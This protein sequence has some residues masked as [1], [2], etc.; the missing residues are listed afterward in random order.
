MTGWYPDHHKLL[1]PSADESSPSLQLPDNMPLL[2]LIMKSYDYSTAGFVSS[3]SVGFLADY[4]DKFIEFDEQN[5]PSRLTGFRKTTNA[6]LDWLEKNKD[7]KFFLFIHFWDPHS[8]YEPISKHD[9]FKSTQLDQLS[10]KAAKYAGEIQYMDSKIGELLN[11]IK[12]LELEKDTLILFTSDHGE[13]FGE[14]P[15]DDFTWN[16]GPCED[17]SVSVLD[18][19]I[20]IPLIIKIPGM[21]AKKIESISQSVDLLPTILD[22]VG[23]P[24]TQP[25]D[26]SSLLDLIG[27]DENENRF[28]Y[29]IIPKNLV[30]SN[31]YT[32][33]LRWKEWK[34]IRVTWIDDKTHQ[35]KFILRLHN[36]TLGEKENFL[37]KEP[38][39]VKKLLQQ[40]EV[41][42][43][44]TPLQGLREENLD[45]ET[46]KMLKSL[47]Y[48]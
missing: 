10:I 24:Q 17:H 25:T 4:F 31:I 20:K 6:S 18:P 34:L 22:L 8:P 41:L 5:D 40:I 32:S 12:K 48:L 7:E 33:G 15:C 38:D 36:T 43:A 35:N 1:I 21:N 42:E 23:I 30:E 11:E 9:V 3:P 44:E 19:E 13:N 47:G 39:L 45:D 46:I 37:A 26:G 29:S 14:Y 2:P 28:A 27:G 16:S